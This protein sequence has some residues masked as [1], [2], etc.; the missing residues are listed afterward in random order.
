MYTKEA[1]ENIHDKG[2]VES[3]NALGIT[4]T[5]KHPLFALLVRHS[6]FIL[7][8]SVEDAFAHTQHFPVRVAQARG[9]S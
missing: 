3:V 5:V 8:Y 4:F 7:N 1:A 2:N 6:E 9:D